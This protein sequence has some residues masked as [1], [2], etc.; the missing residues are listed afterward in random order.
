MKLTEFFTDRPPVK[1]TDIGDSISGIIVDEPELQ[2]DK[3]G[4]AGEKVLVLAIRD[5]SDGAVRRL[6][7]RKQMLGA[8]GQAVA[9]ADVDE[10]E[11]GGRLAVE[12]VADKHTGGASPMKVYEAAYAPPASVGVGAQE[13]AGDGEPLAAAANPWAAAGSDA[14]PSF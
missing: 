3:Y 2:P 12:Y 1:F 9:D 10:I 11:S 7:A 5:K 14:P 4:L 13:W 6:F 8:I